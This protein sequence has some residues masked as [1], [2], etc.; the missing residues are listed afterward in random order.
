MILSFRE[1]QER[2][3]ARADE[4]RSRESTEPTTSAALFA[5]GMRGDD[6][7][8]TLRSNEPTS[9]FDHEQA[10]YEASIEWLRE[11]LGADQT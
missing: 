3:K 4:Y 11:F 1:R 7:G 9:R 10:R 8:H 5:A 2:I 6:I